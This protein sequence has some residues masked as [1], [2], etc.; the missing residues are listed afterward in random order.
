MNIMQLVVIDK[1]KIKINLVE[2]MDDKVNDEADENKRRVAYLASIITIVIIA[3][4]S[5]I[6]KYRG[7]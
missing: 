2:K 6:H 7:I 4:N 5:Q 1:P 3:Y